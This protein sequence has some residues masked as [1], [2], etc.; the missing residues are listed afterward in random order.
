MSNVRSDDDDLM[1][2]SNRRLPTKHQGQIVS[3]MMSIGIMREVDMLRM[4]GVVIR[5]SIDLST[6]GIYS[7]KHTNCV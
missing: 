5:D 6:I 3:E 7:R 1:A 2:D 4:L